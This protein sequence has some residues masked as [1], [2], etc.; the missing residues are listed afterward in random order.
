MKPDNMAAWSSD[1]AHFCRPTRR[2]FLY[3][4]LL[5]GLGLTLDDLFRLEARAETPAATKPGKPHQR[6]RGPAAKSV[7]HIF[8]P[9][10]MSHQESFDPKPYAPIEYRGE[11]GTVPTKLGGVLFNELL[12]ETAQVDDKITVCRSMTH[13]DAAHERG[14]HNIFTGYRPSPAIPV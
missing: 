14:T 3:V 6:S 5:G 13:G 9:G 7:I 2:S 10:G 11:M 8:L 1:P 4:G 12:K